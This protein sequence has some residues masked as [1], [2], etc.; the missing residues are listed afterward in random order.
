MKTHHYM[1]DIETF[2]RR[3]GCVVKSV[4]LCRFDP[5]TGY[6]PTL[7]PPREEGP[8]PRQDAHPADHTLHVK[9]RLENDPRIGTVDPNTV[10]WWLQ[11]SDEA[12]AG[13]FGYEVDCHTGLSYILNWVDLDGLSRDTQNRVL[14]SNGPTFDEVILRALFERYKIDFPWHYRSSSCCRTLLRLAK[15]K[16]FVFAETRREDL[17]LVHHNA[18]HD[19]LWQAHGVCAMYSVLGLSRSED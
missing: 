4:G 15:Q 18:L 13:L 1:L 14:W 10:E 17:N 5:I 16:F 2:G 6:V 11:Q 3:P 7:S 12:R 19:A 9:F 8:T